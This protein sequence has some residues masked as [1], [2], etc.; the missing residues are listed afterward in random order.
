MIHRTK[1][2]ALLAY[3]IVF[4]AVV[5]FIAIRGDMYYLFWYFDMPMHFLGGLSA[6]YLIC[7]VFYTKVQLYTKLPIFYLLLGVLVIGLG[8]EVFEYIFLNL[9]A[10]QPFSF[11]DSLSDIFFDLAGGS[12]GILYI[13]R[14]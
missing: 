13:S 6:M 4:L 14:K 7:Y 2:L 11:S 8:W 12:L 5:N 10:G 1:L 3:S 9:Y